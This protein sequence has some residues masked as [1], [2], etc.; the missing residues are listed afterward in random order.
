MSC[1]CCCALPPPPPFW[2]FRAKLHADT[3]L[4]PTRPS[5]VPGMPETRGRFPP[6]WSGWSPG[7][8]APLPRSRFPWDT[9]RFEPSNISQTSML[10]G[11]LLPNP[12]TP[13]AERR[14]R[15]S[16][17]LESRSAFRFNNAFR[18]AWKIN[19]KGMFTLKEYENETLLS[20]VA[21]LM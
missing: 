14:D 8:T 9:A 10:R 6:G 15:S 12:K 13:D 20:R 7:R 1:P 11:T 16:W 4:R 5:V 18:F 2:G 21:Y 3:A 19:S 17:I